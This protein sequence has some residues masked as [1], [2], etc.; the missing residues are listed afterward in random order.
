M[1]KAQHK[2]IEF[3]K[4]IKR[5][6]IEIITGD[7]RSIEEKTRL[8]GLRKPSDLRLIAKGRSVSLKKLIEYCEALK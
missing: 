7:S 4:T 3:A 2:K 8:L 1:T 5:D 6:L